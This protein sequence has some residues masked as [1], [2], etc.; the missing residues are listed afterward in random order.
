M[1][2]IIALLVLYEFSAFAEVDSLTIHDKTVLEI[3]NG[4]E[5]FQSEPDFWDKY[6]SG[7]IALATVILSLWISY[8]QAKKSI[9]ATRANSI[10]EARIEWIQ[11]LRPIMG[12][13]I[14]DI[15]VF[16]YELEKRIR[17]E[18][19]GVSSPV[20]ERLLELL[21]HLNLSFNKIKLFL[22]HDEDEH[23]VFIKQVD[24][25]IEQCVQRANGNK[26]KVEVVEDELI[27]SARK[28]LK[29]AWEQAK[30]EKGTK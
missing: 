12:K 29:E 27:E 6:S 14:S 16:E 5:I 26:T 8:Y 9:K 10:S 4:K 7:L 11:N 22:N 25:F 1:K 2:W 24:D 20:D 30:S 13:L 21:E 17:N 18:E 15:G 19:K 3:V 23:L 28:I